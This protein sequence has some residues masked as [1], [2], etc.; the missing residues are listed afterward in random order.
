VYSEFESKNYTD[1]LC[2]SNMAV[3]RRQALILIYNFVQPTT[4]KDKTVGNWW[5]Q[6]NVTISPVLGE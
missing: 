4:I 5:G 1:S 2:S 6:F 3:I